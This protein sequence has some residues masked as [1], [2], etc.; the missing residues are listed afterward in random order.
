ME[1]KS[2]MT[3]VGA[4]AIIVCA[5]FVGTYFYKKKRLPF[6]KPVDHSGKAVKEN[7]APVKKHV[8]TLYGYWRSSSTWRVRLVLA[9]K[10]FHLGKE[11]QYIPISLLKDGGEH[12]SEAYSKIN[13]A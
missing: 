3:A 13:P 8:M 2:K 12:K 9:L 6:E 7:G 4:T 11:V 10:G 5:A 1:N